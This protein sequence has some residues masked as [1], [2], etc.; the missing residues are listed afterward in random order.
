M[1]FHGCTRL[2]VSVNSPPTDKK[3]DFVLKGI[4]TGVFL[5]GATSKRDSM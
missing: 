2:N 1:W 5:W 3:K 4:G